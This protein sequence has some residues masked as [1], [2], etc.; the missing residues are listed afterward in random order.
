MEYKEWQKPMTTR[1]YLHGPLAERVATLWSEGKIVL[2]EVETLKGPRIP[3]YESIISCGVWP[4]FGMNMES[5][6]FKKA[7]NIMMAN[8]IPVHSLKNTFENI[9]FNLE[10]F[11]DLNR[12]STVF[13]K[14]KVKNISN[15]DLCDRVGFLL[16]TGFE[17]KLVFDAPDVY[18]SYAPDVDVWKNISSN[19]KRVG[20]EYRDGEYFL[21]SVSEFEFDECQGLIYK[22]INLK[23]CE[24]IEFEFSLG[25]GT[26]WEFKYDDLRLSVI[27]FYEEELKRITKLPDIIKNNPKSK[28]VKVFTFA[29]I[30]L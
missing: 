9:E 18:K 20:N 21:Y 1:R 7:E 13:F 24:E 23:P 4:V 25:K 19:W 30:L 5:P 26:S 15:A 6:D 29:I 22:D 27:R 12:K 11:C 28:Y 2:G 14:V 8:G 16:R 3:E 10:A 17:K